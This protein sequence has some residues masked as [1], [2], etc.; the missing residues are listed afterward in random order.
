MYILLGGLK[1]VCSPTWFENLV[2]LES[3][4]REILR[5]Y[6]KYY[7]KFWKILKQFCKI[8]KLFLKIIEII[9]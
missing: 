9:Y 6:N 1:S 7:D 4:V 2:K 8:F 3:S 5:T